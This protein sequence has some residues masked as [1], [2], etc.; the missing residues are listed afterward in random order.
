MK[1]PRAHY[2]L[3]GGKALAVIVGLLLISLVGLALNLDALILDDVSP[4][5][6][7]T[8][9]LIHLAVLLLLMTYAVQHRARILWQ[10]AHDGVLGTRLQSRIITMFCGIAIVPTLIVAGFSILFFNVGIKSWFDTQVS[11]VLEDSVLVATAYVEEHKEAIRNAA[12]SMSER[13]R[14]VSSERFKNEEEFSHPRG[15]RAQ[16]VGSDYF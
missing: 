6:T 10:R 1:A 4:K 9:V 7:V 16:F 3:R 2:R 12:L 5:R 13:V 14:G 11:S 8:L 15:E